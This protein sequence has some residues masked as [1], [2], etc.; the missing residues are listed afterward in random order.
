MA[1]PPCEFGIIA[2]G[3]LTRNGGNPLIEGDDDLIVRVD[4]TRLVGAG[5]FAVLPVLHMTMMNDPK[6]QEYTLRFLE[7][8]YFIADEQRQP[9][10]Q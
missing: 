2:G 8:G 6:V 5:D 3:K 10:P 1:I 7:Y 9:I 4:E